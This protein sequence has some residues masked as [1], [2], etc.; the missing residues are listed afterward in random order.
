[1]NDNNS[2]G[3]GGN[4]SNSNG[5]G[6]NDKTIVRLEDIR[7]TF[8][9]QQ[10]KVVAVDG[11]DL[12]IKRGQV[13]CII[14]PSGSGKS[15]LLRCINLLEQPDSGKVFF[16]NQEISKQ[17][18]KVFLVRERIG[19]VFQDFN[20]FS[21]LNVL[22]NLCLA[23]VKIRKIGKKE[24]QATARMLLKK[25]GLEDKEH[26]YPSELSGGQQQRAAIARALAM[27]PKLILFD[28]PTSA[29]DPEMIREVL[30]VMKQLAEE[31]MTMLLVSHEMGFAKE[32]A[33]RVYFMDGGR[34]IEQGTPSEVFDRPQSSRTKDFLS[35]ILS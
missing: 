12:E 19:M 24:A 25:V 14:G 27:N 16:E 1:M 2:S 34:I 32:V 22:Q 13:A 3:N 21:H 33:N 5:G 23:P 11:V 10:K 7:K 15:T 26:S 18:K 9:I 31:G 6:N 8:T 29:L 35:H 20:L 30:N 4:N 17:K 28:E